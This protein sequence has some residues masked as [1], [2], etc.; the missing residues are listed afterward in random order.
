L[1][2]FD[3]VMPTL[4]SA[5]RIGERVFKKVLQRIFTEIHVNRLIVVDDGSKDMTL[6]ILKE[7]D[8]TLLSGVG[9]LGKA[10]EI[11]VRNVETEWFYFIDDDN[12]IPRGFHNKMWRYV[13]SK[14]GMIFPKAVVPYDNYVVRYETIMGR[15]RKAMG[16]KDTVE[17]RGFTGATLVRTQAIS[18]IEIPKI[19]RQEDKFIKNYCEHQGWLVKY[20]SDVIV[21]HLHPNL[22]SYKTQYLEGYGLAKVKAISQKRIMFSWLSTYLKVLLAFPFIRNSEALKEIPKMYYVKYQGYRI[23]ERLEGQRIEGNDE[24]EMR[25]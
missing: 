13:D 10:R 7:F 22:P 15:L 2:K 5:S 25:H 20:A 4:N 3:V 8:V 14:T 6:D 24:R 18:D 23:C 21:L 9:S 12:L 16:L 19:A 11:G 17:N 1:E